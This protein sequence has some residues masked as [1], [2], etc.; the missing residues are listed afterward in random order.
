MDYQSGG[1]MPKLNGKSV[2]ALSSFYFQNEIVCTLVIL[3]F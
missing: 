3:T 2:S 1:H